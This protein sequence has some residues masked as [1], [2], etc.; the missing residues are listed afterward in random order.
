MLARTG[1]V[2]EEHRRGPSWS[3]RVTPVLEGACHTVTRCTWVPEWA[4]SETCSLL[5]ASPI[6]LLRPI[7]CP[8]PSSPRASHERPNMADSMDVDPV[9]E[10]KGKTKED[11]KGDKKRF[12]VK[13]VRILSAVCDTYYSSLYLHGA[14]MYW[15]G[16]TVERCLA[17]GV[18]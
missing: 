17:L 6:R 7:P 5:L 10:P 18:G 16:T 13:K 8:S 12:E 1:K 4:S 14:F 15:L 3:G 2:V 11:G 9:V